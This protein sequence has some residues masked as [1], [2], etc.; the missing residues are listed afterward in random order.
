MSD[1]QSQLNNFDSNLRDL[2]LYKYV[3]KLFKFEETINCL[4]EKFLIQDA[5]L[6][7][8]TG[9][10]ERYEKILRRR[11][12]KKLRKFTKSNEFLY[13]ECLGQFDSHEPFFL[14]K[15][16]FLNF[17]NTFVPEFE[18]L[19]TLIHLNDVSDTNT[20]FDDSSISD[21][22]NSE[23]CET[24]P[25]SDVKGNEAEMCDGLLKGK[26]VNKNVISLSK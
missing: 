13:L 11:K 2:V 7:K 19:H 26:F 21:S 12:L 4:F 14:F 9:H 8:V 16:Q 6:L 24:K 25:S 5:W 10:L 15:H 1:W 20:T 3:E 17:C 22:E 23:N 18:N